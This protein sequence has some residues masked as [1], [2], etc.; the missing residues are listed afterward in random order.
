MPVAFSCEEC[1]APSADLTGWVNVDIQFWHYD[2]PGP[3]APGQVND[4]APVK[5]YFDKPE[6]RAAWCLKAGV[7][8]PPSP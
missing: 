3:G 6:C 2:P 4:G 8:P 7:E 5:L 1:G